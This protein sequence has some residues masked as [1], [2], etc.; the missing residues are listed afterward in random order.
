MI[1]WSSS[2]QIC[3][4]FRVGPDR[5]LSYATRGNLGFRRLADGTQE[6][7]L[8]QVNRLFAPRQA[9][10]TLPIARNATS[11]GQLGKLRLGTTE[12]LQAL[13]SAQPRP[14]ETG[15]DTSVEVPT[16]HRRR[17]RATRVRQS[18]VG[19]SRVH[20]SVPYP[21]DETQQAG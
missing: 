3:R 11:L 21:L 2:E 13:E 17:S 1:E 10:L 16:A 7:D 15:A 5:L 14:S 6:Y 20:P 18:E 4:D 9:C 12:V 19:F 8:S